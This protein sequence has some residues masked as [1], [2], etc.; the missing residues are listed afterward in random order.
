[1]LGKLKSMINI[2]TNEVINFTALKGAMLNIEGAGAGNPVINDS[3]NVTSVTRTGV[4]V[5]NV[6]P[7]QN[8][9]YG[10]DIF[11]N[12]TRAANGVIAPTAASDA[13]FVELKTGVGSTFDIV[14]TEMVQGVGNRIDFNPYDII[15]GDNVTVSVLVNSGLGQ[16]PPP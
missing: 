7:I 5:Y 13:H 4:G 9:F 10:L 3:Y 16:L 14:I 11:T 8:T 12:S 1:M 15:A 2:L 6:V